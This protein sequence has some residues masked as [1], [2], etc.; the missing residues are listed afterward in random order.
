[1]RIGTGGFGGLLLRLFEKIFCRLAER[2]EDLQ[3]GGMG[4][5]DFFGFRIGFG[6]DLPRGIEPGQFLFTTALPGAPGGLGRFGARREL[7]RDRFENGPRLRELSLL[8][9]RQG[10]M[11]L[12]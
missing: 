10:M 3:L 5:S 1:M 12:N 6:D 9:Q 7:L 11:V 2:L 4:R 8:L